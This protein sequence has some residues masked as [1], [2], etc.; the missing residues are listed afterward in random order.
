M[1]GV[2]GSTASD[3][4][5]TPSRDNVFVHV[6]PP[7]VDLNTPRDEPADALPG[8]ATR[9]T[10][11]SFG[12]TTMAA[13]MWASAR[14]AFVPVPPLS[15]DFQTPFPAQVPPPAPTYTMFGSEAATATAP[16]AASRTV[17]VIG[18]QVC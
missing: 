10:P 6:F 8:A 2:A 12:S 11:G 9:T 13:M 14:P 18:L 3:E 7:S 16:I 15:I 5:P 1:C 17:S 4:D